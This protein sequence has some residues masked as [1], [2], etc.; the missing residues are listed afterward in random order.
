M[1]SVTLGYNYLNI[2]PHCH[3]NGLM[4][5]LLKHLHLLQRCLIITAKG[6]PEAG[7]EQI[8]SRLLTGYALSDRKRLHKKRRAKKRMGG[9]NIFNLL[10]RLLYRLHQNR[11]AMTRENFHIHAS[12][13]ASGYQ[14]A[15][16]PAELPGLYAMLSPEICFLSNGNTRFETP[17]GLTIKPF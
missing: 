8:E 3:L 4:Q 2:S 11:L 1:R 7:I 10:Q 12:A 5:I 14:P 13:S 17:F 16:I 9:K 6:L 15:S